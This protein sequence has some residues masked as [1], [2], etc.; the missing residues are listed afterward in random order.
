LPVISSKTCGGVVENGRNGIILE[1][2]SAPCIAAAIR[3]CM[4][5]PNRLQTL[6]AG[7]YRGSEFTTDMLGQRLQELGSGL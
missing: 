2:P 1:E 6:A 4:V 3:E 7:S 5:D